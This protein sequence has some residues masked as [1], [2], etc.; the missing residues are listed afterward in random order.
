MEKLDKLPNGWPIWQ[1]STEFKFTLDAVLLAAFPFLRDDLQIVELGSGCGAVSLMLAARCKA[2]IV[3]V[4]INEKVNSLFER[5]I[6]L[7]NLS[8]QISSVTTDVKNI[9]ATFVHGAYDLVISNPPYRKIGQGRLRKSG[10]QNACHE[11]TGTTSD[12]IQA[13]KF[14]LKYKGKFVLVH[15]AERLPEILVEC[16][17]SGLEPKRL[18]FV[19]AKENKAANLFLLEMI[20][21]GNKSL[22]VLPPLIVY[23]NEGNYT[24]EV[25]QS[26]SL[27]K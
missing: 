27:K 23:D 13:A 26:Y 5:S 16:V 17:S 25:L 19:H 24:K 6:I 10:A 20:K 22:Q 18:Q 21:G 7:N 2:K 15:L 8:E 4:D 9:K 1:D 14:L 12:F 11:V 3:G